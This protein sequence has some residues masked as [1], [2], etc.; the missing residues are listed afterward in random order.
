LVV[1]FLF[2]FMYAWNDFLLARIMLQRQQL[3]TWPLGLQTLQGQ[4]T[5]Q[6]GIFATCSILISVPV[7][8]LFLYSSKWLVSGLTIGSVKG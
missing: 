6:W 7:L 3:Y 4:F 1:A 8:I 2:N 5:T